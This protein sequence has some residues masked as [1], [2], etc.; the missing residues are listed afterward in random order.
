MESVLPSQMNCFAYFMPQIFGMLKQ[1]KVVTFGLGLKQHRVP[2]N[3]L[4]SQ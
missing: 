4:Q 2:N 1:G 3:Y